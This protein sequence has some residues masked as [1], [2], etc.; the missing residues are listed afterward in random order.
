[1]CELGSGLDSSTSL[2][3]MTPLCTEVSSAISNVFLA[4][5][6]TAPEN[7]TSAM[8]S[9][10]PPDRRPA[11]DAGG[12]R[13]GRARLGEAVPRGK[14]ASLVL[15]EAKASALPAVSSTQKESAPQ[16]LIACVSQI[17]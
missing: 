6:S 5:V 11:R 3:Y 1:M 16:T 17:Y 10:D 13:P 2:T 8:R 14:T 9:G 7:V 4:S 12:A 15:S